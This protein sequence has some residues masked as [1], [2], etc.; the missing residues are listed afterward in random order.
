MRG[1]FGDDEGKENVVLLMSRCYS[2]AGNEYCQARGG[3]ACTH[4]YKL[5][6]GGLG[7]LGADCN[8]TA[9]NTPSDSITL[10]T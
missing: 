7:G 10:L 9:E 2:I 4:A 1:V 6:E 3:E 5:D 8:S